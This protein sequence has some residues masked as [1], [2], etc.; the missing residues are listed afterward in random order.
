MLQKLLELEVKL[1]LGVIKSEIFKRN[2][3][4]EVEGDLPVVWCSRQGVN[5]HRHQ[6]HVDTILNLYSKDTA[7]SL[8]L[9]ITITGGR[10]DVLAHRAP[11]E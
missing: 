1:R 7:D 4:T 2:C 11:K 3:T 10:Q 9:G 5:Y 6:H 8:K